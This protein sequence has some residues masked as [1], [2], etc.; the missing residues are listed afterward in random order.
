MEWG[1]HEPIC[2]PD[3]KWSK[4]FLVPFSRIC[5]NAHVPPY[6]AATH[7]LSAVP[8]LLPEDAAIDQEAVDPYGGVCIEAP[9]G[10][11]Y[12]IRE[13]YFNPLSKPMPNLPDHAHVLKGHYSIAGLLAYKFGLEG[14]GL[15]SSTDFSLIA[16]VVRAMIAGDN[17]ASHRCNN[18][19]CVRYRHVCYE[20]KGRDRSRIYCAT[21]CN[22]LCNARL[23]GVSTC[24]HD[25]P[26]LFNWRADPHGHF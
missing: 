6:A 24:P 9:M 26:C 23:N 20:P 22:P 25:P 11:T 13:V 4:P 17:C 1:V 19:R 8:L 5:C 2:P 15:S 18:S 3:R 12:P 7:I 10:R 14:A 21:L 16:P